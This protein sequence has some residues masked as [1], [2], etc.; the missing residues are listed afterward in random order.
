MVREVIALVSP[1][2]VARPGSGAAGA[3]APV[4]VVL[5]PDPLTRL[6]VVPAVAALGFRLSSAEPAVVPPHAVFIPLSG[7]GDC[8]RSADGARALAAAE[9]PLV[10]AYAAGPPALLAAHRAH[11]C[12]DLVLR[13]AA[14]EAGD[15]CL[16]HLP[17]RDAVVRAGLSA[18]EADVL[19][20]LLHG[21]TTPVIAERL[22]VSA[23]T[24][25]THCRAVL[26][27]FGVCDRRRLRD[28]VAAG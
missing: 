8:R 12:A 7:A 19:V 22:G 25:R 18:R 24:A 1:H 27:K 5:E 10:V 3:P 9:P 14:S 2:V 15:P 6:L 28:L 20:L 11:G 21:L 26:R 17:A 16:S 4:A 13:L 23:S